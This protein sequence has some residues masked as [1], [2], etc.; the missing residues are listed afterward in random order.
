MRH[1]KK[2]MM[3][4]MATCYRAKRPWG[5]T[6]EKKGRHCEFQWAFPLA[7]DKARREGFDRNSFSGEVQFAGEYPGC[8]YCGS[9]GFFQCGKCNAVT[10]LPEDAGSKVTRPACGTP[11]TLETGRDFDFKGGGY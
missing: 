11:L 2:D 5:I 7:Q 6:I 3:V 9:T 1:P 10:C 8:P 4:V